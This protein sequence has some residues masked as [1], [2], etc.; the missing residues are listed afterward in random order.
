MNSVGDS[1]VARRL[2]RLAALFPPSNLL[3]GR[4][5]PS[6][7][8]C[9][10]L[11]RLDPS[12]PVLPSLV[13]V[14]YKSPLLAPASLAKLTSCSPAAGMLSSIYHDALAVSWDPLMFQPSRSF[15]KFS[16]AWHAAPTFVI[17]VDSCLSFRTL[18]KEPFLSC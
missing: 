13:S 17:L 9:T 18:A 16:L 15:P 6:C 1:F 2:E 11:T 12:M 10:G 7:R 5:S 14:R 8:A 3:E 4:A